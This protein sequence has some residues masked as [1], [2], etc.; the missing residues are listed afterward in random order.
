MIINKQSCGETEQPPPLP[1]SGDGWVVGRNS[2]CYCIIKYIY[3]SVCLNDTACMTACF[4]VCLPPP[5]P[6]PFSVVF[7]SGLVS[8]GKGSSNNS[9]I[10]SESRF[11]L[12]I[13]L[14]SHQFYRDHYYYYTYLVLFSGNG[15]SD[16]GKAQLAAAVTEFHKSMAK[17]LLG[18]IS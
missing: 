16:T 15:A 14:A 5:Q 3:I 7:V 10:A 8:A 9:S 18:N 6:H 17:S 13:P 12:N 11:P 4:S 2:T 1:L